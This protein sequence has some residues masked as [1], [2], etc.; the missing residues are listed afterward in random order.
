MLYDDTMNVAQLTIQGVEHTDA[1]RYRCEVTNRLGRVDSTCRLAVSVPP[2][3]EYDARYAGAHDVK[4]GASLVL[5]V[6]FTGA[7]APR[8]TW[9]R[10]GISLAN[11]PGHVNIDTGS[12]YSTL[13]ILG[14]YHAFLFWN[15]RSFLIAV[16]FYKTVE[17]NHVHHNV[18][19]RQQVC[20]HKP[21]VQARHVRCLVRRNRSRRGRSV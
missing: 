12:N 7:P 19:Y 5:P 3:L 8:V 2:K 16:I 14:L 4:A 21:S 18:V 17:H 1:G 9:L 13:T 20:L 6:N 10:N 15:N 11:I